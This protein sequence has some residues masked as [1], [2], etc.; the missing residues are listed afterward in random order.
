[1]RVLGR[2]WA[3][4]ARAAKTYWVDYSMDLK[5]NHTFTALAAV[6]ANTALALHTRGFIPRTHAFQFVVTGA[7]SAAD[8]DI[9]GSLDGTNW[10]DLAANINILTTGNPT[11]LV[12]K[13]VNYIRFNLETL[14]GGTAPTVT[15]FYAG[16]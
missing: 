15:V 7:P 10:F 6:G 3:T 2:C 14:T 4:R 13:P 11:F 1:M 9:E 16:V 5:I 8:G 12:D